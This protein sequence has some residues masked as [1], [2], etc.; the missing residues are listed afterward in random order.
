MQR[1]SKIQWKSINAN[2]LFSIAGASA[3]ISA[4]L[5]LVLPDLTKQKMPCTVNEIETLQFSGD[6]RQEQNQQNSGS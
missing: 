5:I 4:F 3:L 2:W 1:F 6:R